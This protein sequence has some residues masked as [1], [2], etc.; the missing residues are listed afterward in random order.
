[1]KSNDSHRTIVTTLRC[2]PRRTRA[3][4]RVL[5]TDGG[6]S[7]LNHLDLRNNMIADSSSKDR[8]AIRALVEALMRPMRLGHGQ[9]QRAVMLEL[10]G[11]ELERAMA[12]DQDE[13]QGQG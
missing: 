7:S 4:A 11:N 5:A 10:N 1:M 12:L 9:A 13:G 3:L 6:I 2:P 8:K